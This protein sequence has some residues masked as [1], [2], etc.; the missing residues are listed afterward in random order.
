MQDKPDFKQI[1]LETDR[2]ILKELNPEI[3]Y[4]LFTFFNDEEIKNYMGLR[5]E[6]ELELERMRFEQGNATF[7]ISFKT[8]LLIDKATGTVVGRTGFHNWYA[9]HFRA[10]IGYTITD[11]NFLQKGYMTEANKAVVEYGFE[12]MD[13]NRIEAFIAAYNTPSLKILLRLGFKKEGTLRQH[14]FVNNKIEDSD[15]YG[16]LKKEYYA[17]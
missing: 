9:H 4:N 5:S 1:I 15:C 11:E 12:H 6:N 13:L 16:L 8:F 10:E 3:I 14:Y 2:L 17:R 7:N